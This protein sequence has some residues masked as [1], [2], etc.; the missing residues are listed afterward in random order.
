MQLL[1]ILPHH[2]P[3]GAQET[4][5]RVAA[6]M[7]SVLWATKQ[8]GAPAERLLTASR[9]AHDLR[10][11]LAVLLTQVLSPA[12]LPGSLGASKIRVYLDTIFTP[13]M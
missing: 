1:Q 13:V 2:E 5:V 11:C 8:L 7:H 10:V 3:T 6:D 12:M 4:A 9:V